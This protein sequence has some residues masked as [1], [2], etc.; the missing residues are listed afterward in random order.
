MAL[1]AERSQGIP[2]SINNLCF[3]AMLLGYL[4]RQ[5]IIDAEIV[6]KAAAKLDM[7]LLVRH[8]DQDPAND[9]IPAG[10][11]SGLRVNPSELRVNKWSPHPIPA[12]PPSELGVNPSDLRVN[13][14]LPVRQAGS[15]HPQP[16]ASAAS[17]GSLQL[18][19]LL[20]NAL[21]GESRPGPGRVL[22]A[23]PKAGTTLTGK[24]TEKLTSQS[25]SKK[26]EFRI[27][28][29]L[30]REIS[31]AIPVADRYYC[32]NFYVSEEQAASLRPGKPIRIKFEQD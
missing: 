16:A 18:A 8:P 11:P 7:E 17:L 14:C 3:N 9:I 4:H 2:R 13:K 12:G 27:Q 5:E 26:N 19:H 21:A 25:W 24:L 30:E 28:V 31:S 23:K 1:I 32:C 6:E 15:P 22:R 10:S 29:S 20:L